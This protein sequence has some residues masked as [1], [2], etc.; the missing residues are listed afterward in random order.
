[1]IKRWGLTKTALTFGFAM[2]RSLLTLVRWCKEE[3]V[4]FGVPVFPIE[5]RAKTL[6]D[7]GE[8]GVLDIIRER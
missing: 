8:D 7:R 5:L 3:E 2:W 1:M 6:G 4:I